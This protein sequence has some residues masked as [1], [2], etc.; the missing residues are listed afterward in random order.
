MRRTVGAL[1][2][3]LASTATPS[4]PAS[5]RL[6]ASSSFPAR[7]LSTVRHGPPSHAARRCLFIITCRPAGLG[8]SFSFMAR[9]AVPVS[10]LTDEW[11]KPECA[12]T[13]AQS[14]GSDTDLA[15]TFLTQQ[16]NGEHSPG[17]SNGGGR[18][19]MARTKSA[20]GDPNAA[21]AA[22]AAAAAAA[23]EWSVM[24]ADGQGTAN[25]ADSA[26]G[27]TEA[28]GSA[29]A[30]MSRTK[31]TPGDPAAAAAAIA[32]AT[33]AASEWSRAA[34][35]RVE[36]AHAWASQ[37]R[38]RSKAAD[39]VVLFMIACAYFGLCLTRS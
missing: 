4:P 8:F 9:F 3:R 31:S 33:A 32:A 11:R 15:V 13:L 29:G 36:A 39:K 22:V 25:A 21:A 12:S 18:E 16:A 37:N 5:P 6:G 27:G 1:E 7:S 23:A 28:A 24:Q 10:K 38:S 26:E 35:G 30:E 34:S 19:D 20:P 2:S 17:S 14:A